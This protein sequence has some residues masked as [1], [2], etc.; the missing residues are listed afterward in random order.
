[1]KPLFAPLDYSGLELAAAAMLEQAARA[2]DRHR[3]A[4]APRPAVSRAHELWLGYLF[5]LEE[6]ISIAPL[7]PGALD[8]ADVRGLAIL[9]R[10]RGK[11]SSEHFACRCGAILPNWA[12]FCGQCGEKY[13]RGTGN[14]STAP[15]A[16]RDTETVQ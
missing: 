16:G 8:E 14:P 4:A 5:A 10:T 15:R 7:P 3:S 13:R 9:R 6:L 11:F 12:G 2:R 1:M